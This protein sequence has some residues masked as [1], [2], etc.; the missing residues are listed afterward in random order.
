MTPAEIDA[1]AAALLE[2]ERKGRQIGLLSLAHPGMTMDDAAVA[3]HAEVRGG[4]RRGPGGREV[5]A[6]GS[7]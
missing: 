5:G 7:S 6:V 2:A 4:S 1:A 3:Q